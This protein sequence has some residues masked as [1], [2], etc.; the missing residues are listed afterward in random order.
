MMNPKTVLITGASRGLGKAMALA[1]ATRGYQVA[2]HYRSRSDDAKAVQEA[3]EALGVRAI[4][5]QG[6]V[7]LETDA[8]HVLDATLKAFGSLD[9]LVNNAGVLTSGTLDELSLDDYQRTMTINTASVWLMVKHAK[10]ALQKTQGSI[11]NISSGSGIVGPP[12]QSPY[13]SSKA[14]VNGLT[15]A[16]ANELAAD[17][18]RV[19]AVAPGLIP[20]DMTQSRIDEGVETYLKTVPLGTLGTPEDIA[21]AVCFFASEDARFITGQIMPVNGGRHGM[22]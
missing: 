13:V 4:T 14:A 16:F 2:I 15:K 7:S 8:K 18:I 6:D 20:T 19:N 5:V 10:A 21:N 22:C 17:G 9:V 1:F 3:C 11:I 12:N